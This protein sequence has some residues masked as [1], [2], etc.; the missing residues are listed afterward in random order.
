[1]I[2]PPLHTEPEDASTSKAKIGAEEFMARVESGARIRKQ[3]IVNVL[4]KLSATFRWEQKDLESF[5]AF[6][7]Q[8]GGRLSNR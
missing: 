5:S 4:T 6:Y 8:R 7:R 2:S 1:M 3:L